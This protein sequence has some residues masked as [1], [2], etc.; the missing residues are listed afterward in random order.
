M[1]AEGIYAI[2]QLQN[3]DLCFTKWAG[4]WQEESSSDYT[5]VNKDSLQE[6]MEIFA[7]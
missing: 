6:L 3:N 2:K 5:F 1:L 7:V 4:V